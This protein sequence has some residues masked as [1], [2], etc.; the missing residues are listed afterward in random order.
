M[1]G[2]HSLALYPSDVIQSG[3]EKFPL[4]GE[5]DNAIFC[6]GQMVRSGHANASL[7]SIANNIIASVSF[8]W[9]NGMKAIGKT[10]DK[11][12]AFILRERGVKMSDISMKRETLEILL[13]LA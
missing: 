3:F 10:F 7:H 4:K 6:F 11:W 12:D 9:P 2:A 1:N 13:P 5:I 8:G